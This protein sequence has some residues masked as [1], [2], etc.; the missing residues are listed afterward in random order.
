MNNKKNLYLV[1]FAILHA[2]I[3]FVLFKNGVYRGWE[4]SDV[5]VPYLYGSR[6][7]LGD[8]P[9][10]DF[11]VEYPPLA[12]LFMLIPRLFS[13]FADA[14]ILGFTLEIL[15]FD[16]LAMIL[17]AAFCRRLGLSLP[18]SLGV[19]TLAVL[20]VGPILINRYDLIPA[21]M[22]LA[23]VYAFTSGRSKIAWA[24]LAVGTMTKIFP[25]VIA[26]I[27]L[28][29]DLVRYQYEKALKGIATFALTA[30]LIALPFIIMSPHGLVESFTYHAQRGL[31]IE[32]VLA[33]V[34]LLM[35]KFGFL[36]FTIELASGAFNIVSPFANA[37]A[38]VTPVLVLISLGVVFW[39]YYRHQ[40]MTTDYKSTDSASS[41]SLSCITSWSLLTVLVF[42]LSNKVLSP[43]FIIWILPFIPLITGSVN[44]LSWLLFIVAGLLSYLIFPTGY[45]NLEQGDIWIVSALLAR[46]AALFGLAI[47]VL[48]EV[49]SNQQI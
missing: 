21:V 32:S 28:I 30:G 12:L 6:I 2:V 40:N 25:V 11:V 7:V 22:T 37:L 20:S 27:F 19:Y 15:I 44:R 46:N 41:P 16:I 33:S 14:Y 17:I 29:Y 43:Q 4:E 42:I 45:L 18:R 10:R 36:N 3:F 49:R 39:M 1:A 35:E 26:P 31:Q 9:Y 48:R 8:I 24:L 5:I 13:S 34:L 23:A 38:K 47:A